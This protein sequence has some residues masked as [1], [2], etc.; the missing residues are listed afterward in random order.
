MRKC[1]IEGC[2]G[3]HL[4]R[5]WCVR[6]Y[7]TWKRCGSPDAPNQQKNTLDDFWARVNRTGDCW[8]WQG[9]KDR[10]GY[11]FFHW[12]N[13]QVRTHRFVAQ[14]VL[15]LDISYLEVCHTC[16]NP[17]C[18]RPSH[19]FVGT[20]KDNKKDS[21]RKGRH[22]KGE[23]HACAVLSERQVRYVRRMVEN[24]VSRVLIAKE[25]H[26]SK[27]CIDFIA[28]RRTWKHI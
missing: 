20:T 6:H 24:G 12:E 4:A 27:T 25:L 22:A 3:K 13:K 8:I 19:L 1:E 9:S 28:Q 10:D 16:D 21:V 26:V 11:G 5:G 17:G 15:K 14:E 7:A 23:T 2:N 18:V